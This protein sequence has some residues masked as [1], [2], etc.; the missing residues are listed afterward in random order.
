V[1]DSKRVSV[2]LH[3][4]K[5][6]RVE[7]TAS[8]APLGVRPYTTPKG[9][10]PK[11]ATPRGERMRV[12]KEWVRGFPSARISLHPSWR[13]TAE[14]TPEGEWRG[15]KEGEWKRRGGEPVG[16]TEKGK[17]KPPPE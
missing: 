8:A 11:E 14:R 10:S 1:E 2:Y 9:A 5:S 17:E 15:R 12:R 4:H 6:G 7:G 13:A 3:P 16:Q